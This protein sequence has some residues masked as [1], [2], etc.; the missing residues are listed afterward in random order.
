[1]AQVGP[2][3]VGKHDVVVVAQIEFAAQADPNGTHI[4]RVYAANGRWL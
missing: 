3:T 4:N 2:I 1:M